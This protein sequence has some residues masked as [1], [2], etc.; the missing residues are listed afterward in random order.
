MKSKL[1]PHVPGLQLQLTQKHVRGQ[2]KATKG[3]NTKEQQEND[4][5]FDL[6]QLC[7]AGCSRLPVAVVV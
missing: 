6:V 7:S 2:A 1:A 4:C 5:C 3:S